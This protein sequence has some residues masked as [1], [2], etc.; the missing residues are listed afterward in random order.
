MFFEKKFDATSKESIARY[1]SEHCR[2][3]TMNGRSF[4][5]S[6]AN[7]VKVPS[8]GL[9]GS[10]LEKA[11]EI[12][13][14]ESYWDEIWY[15]VREFERDMCGGYSIHTNGRNSGYVVL[16][17]AEVYDPGYK[18]TCKCCGQL[19]YQPVTSDKDHCGVCHSPRVNLSKPLS[20]TRTK[21]SSIDHGMTMSDFLDLPLADLK[22]K[23]ALV[24]KF[25][26]TCDRLRAAFI[27]L[28]DDYMIVEET[29]LV[30][31]RVSRLERV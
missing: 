28:I 25:D 2:Y 15:V 27:E 11:A 17:E 7:L 14:V 26:Q 19:N 21:S 20:W 24:R 5:T 13:K 31:C 16:Y 29:V 10:Q 1:L 4:A 3:A 30:E 12:I 6:Y 22:S 23:A 8:I 9:R 18:S